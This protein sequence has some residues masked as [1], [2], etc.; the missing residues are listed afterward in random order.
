MKKP[1]MNKYPER[2]CLECLKVFLPNRKDKVYC[3][4]IC[5]TTYG[6]KHLGHSKGNLKQQNRRSSL[7]KNPYKRYKGVVC[8][9]C[10]FIPTHPCQLDVD[11]IDGNHS[12]NEPKN[13][14]TLCANCHRLKTAIQ[15]GWY[16]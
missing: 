12:N 13:L 6:K 9:T 4:K 5:R 1:P 10:E 16:K 15:L 14:Q 2:A 7:Q 8:Q 11:H 3:S